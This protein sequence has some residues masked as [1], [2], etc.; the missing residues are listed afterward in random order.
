MSFVLE[1]GFVSQKAV[2]TLQLQGYR[3]RSNKTRGNEF[4]LTEGGEVT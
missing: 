3:V 4:K 1:M 2:Q